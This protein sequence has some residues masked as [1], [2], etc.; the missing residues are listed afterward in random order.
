MTKTE[1]DV[2]WNRALREAL[3]AGEEFTR[4][5]FAAMVASAKEAE[6]KEAMRWDIHSCGPTCKRYA[7]VATRE[8]VAAEREA[9]AKV[10]E[11]LEIDKWNLYKG[12]APYTGQ[13]DGRASEYVQGESDGAGQC[14]YAIRA[15][16]Q[17]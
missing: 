4:Y 13:E 1:L 5:R 12:R 17:Q 14:A 11:T 16:G 3:E 7:C 15:R 6:H 2:L 8:A 10:A 9:C